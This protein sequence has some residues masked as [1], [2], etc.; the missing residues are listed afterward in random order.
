MP[1][2]KFCRFPVPKNQAIP[3]NFGNARQVAVTA[4]DNANR[5]LYLACIR[6]L[7]NTISHKNPANA[8]HM[9]KLLYS[10]CYNTTSAILRECRNNL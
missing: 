4:A 7:M 9:L 2:W 10:N 6:A 8:L 3:V 5:N 1:D